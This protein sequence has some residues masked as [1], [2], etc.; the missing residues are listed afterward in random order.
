M[1]IIK[2]VKQIQ[3]KLFLTSLRHG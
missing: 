3:V 1:M 2:S